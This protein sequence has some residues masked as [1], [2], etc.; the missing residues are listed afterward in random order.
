MIEA[1]ITTIL[2]SS[3]VISVAEGPHS[4]SSK[5]REVDVPLLAA[6]ASASSKSAE[7]VRHLARLSCPLLTRLVLHHNNIPEVSMT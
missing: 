4:R 2:S 1:V 7:S 6:L 5:I 3:P